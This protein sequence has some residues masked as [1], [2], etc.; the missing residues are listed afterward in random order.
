MKRCLARIVIYSTLRD[1]LHRLGVVASWAAKRR[2]LELPAFPFVLS[3]LTTTTIE[4]IEAPRVILNLVL[5]CRNMT[6]EQRTSV[7]CSLR[8][9]THDT[10]P[11]HHPVISPATA[12]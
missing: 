6:T 11:A 4:S 5:N 9:A 10:R 12:Q 7:A 2:H 3:G 8:P 1:N